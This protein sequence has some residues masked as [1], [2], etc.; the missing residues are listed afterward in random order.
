MENQIELAQYF[1]VKKSFYKLIQAIVYYRATELDRDRLYDWASLLGDQ[2]VGDMD[3]VDALYAEASLEH[4]VENQRVPL[5]TVKRS[6][7]SPLE[8]VLK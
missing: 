1:S 7:N 2:F 8:Y 3:E 4:L 5:I 6:A